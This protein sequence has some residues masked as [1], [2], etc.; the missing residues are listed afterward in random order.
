MHL[1]QEEKELGSDH[2]LGTVVLPSHDTDLPPGPIED[3][4]KGFG[5]DREARRPSS[6]V[7]HAQH[8]RAA[9][10]PGQAGDVTTPRREGVRGSEP[11]IAMPSNGTSR[12]DMLGTREAFTVDLPLAP[13]RRVL[14]FQ[15]KMHRAFGVKQADGGN[16]EVDAPP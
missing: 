3:L 2:V 6:L 8:H 16:E 13:V 10:V 1:A 12:S 15:P 9:R 4:L 7:N 14:G 11:L 5:I